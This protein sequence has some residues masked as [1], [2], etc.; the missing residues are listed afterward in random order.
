MKSIESF[1]VLSA[2]SV[3][4]AFVLWLQRA[5]IVSNSIDFRER[6]EMFLRAWAD[7]KYGYSQSDFKPLDAYYLNNVHK[8][9]YQFP[10]VVSVAKCGNVAGVRE[11]VE[12]Y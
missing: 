7:I 5:G 12:N 8:T 6:R 11:R 1:R 10:M 3:L 9:V 2:D 4:E